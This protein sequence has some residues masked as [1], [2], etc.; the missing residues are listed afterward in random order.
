MVAEKWHSLN[1]LIREGEYCELGKIAEQF[2]VS[3]AHIVRHLVQ[4]AGRM[5]LEGKPTCVNGGACRC[6]AE[7]G[8]ERWFNLVPRGQAILPV[9]KREG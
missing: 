2:G 1:V 6:E 8:S 7:W 9:M 4:A 5:L 3:R